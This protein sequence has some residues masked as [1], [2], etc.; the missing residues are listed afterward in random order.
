MA[1]LGQQ[2]VFKQNL[3]WTAKMSDA[4]EVARGTY[5][6]SMLLLQRRGFSANT[7]ID[8]GAAEGT[9]FLLR[10]DMGLFPSAKHFFV[11]AMQENEAAYQKLAAKFGTG[12][13]ITAL[14]C[15]EGETVMRIDPHFYNTHIDHIQPG[16]TYEGARRVTVRTLDSVVQRHSLQG[17]FALKLDVQGGELDVLRGGLRT[18]SQAVIVTAEIQIFTE[19]DAIA[20]LLIFMQGN[21]WA[22]YDLTD[23]AYY[24][25][26]HTFY[27]CYA[28]FIPKSLE[29]RRAIPWCLPEQEKVVLERLR[30]R[31]ENNL[32]AIEKLVGQG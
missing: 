23:L 30:V 25:S 18:L 1:R 2:S 15:M 6:A 7:F 20:E 3:S 17:P 32:E 11:D 24:P 21:G 28:T 8:I 31:R 4:R 16:T 9:F 27:Q 14:S 13:E 12:H 22:L 5:M 19:R 10:R 29:F 26:D